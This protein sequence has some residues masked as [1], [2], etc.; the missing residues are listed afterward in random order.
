MK[1]L[2]VQSVE[3]PTGV[4]EVMGSNPVEAIYFFLGFLCNCNC[5]TTAKITFISII[6]L[7]II[8]LFALD[9]FYLFQWNSELYPILDKPFTHA[10]LFLPFMKS[11]VVSLKRPV[12]TEL[13]E[14][15]PRA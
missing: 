12:L 1:G 11:A 6:I 5:F 8:L 7:S 9:L 14:H 2:I 13:K 15:K 4:V 3:H 10:G